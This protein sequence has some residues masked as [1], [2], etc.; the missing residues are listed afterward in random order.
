MSGVFFLRNWGG[1]SADDTFTGFDQANP[2]F[3]L[4][5]SF[6]TDV[7]PGRDTIIAGLGHDFVAAPGGENSIDGGAGDDTL[8]GQGNSDTIIGGAG[9]GDRLAGGSGADLLIETAEPGTLDVAAFLDGGEGLDTLRLIGGGRLVSTQM[10]GIEVL[11]AT[12]GT[13]TISA[14]NFA[15][16]DTLRFGTSQSQTDVLIAGLGGTYDFSALSLQ[17]LSGPLLAAARF[18]GSAGDEAVI[19]TDRADVLEGLGGN[20][21]VLGGAGN[22]AVSGAGRVRGGDGDDSVVDF[23]GAISADRLEGGDGADTIRSFHGADTLN[24]GLDDDYLEGSRDGAD[25]LLGGDGH[26]TL[27]GGA[28]NATIQHALRG[29]GG[30]DRLEA[31]GLLGAGGLFHG[32]DGADTLSVG[33]ATL[34]GATYASIELLAVAGL[35]GIGGAD[36]DAFA[37][38]ELASNAILFAASAGSFDFR[39]KTMLGT[40]AF[41]QGAQFGNDTILGSSLADTLEGAGGADNLAGFDGDDLLAG[42][43]GNDSIDGGAGFDTVRFLR[44]RAD[45]TVQSAG[46]ALIVSGIFEGAD[47]L[48]GVEELRFTDGTVP[49]VTAGNDSV[50]GGTGADSLN[51]GN[52]AD[53]VDGLAGDDTLV[54]SAGDDRVVGGDGLDRILGGNGADTLIGGAGG[55]V[56]SGQAGADLFLFTGLGD[57]LDRIADLTPGIDRIG[58]DSVAFGLAPGAL[59]AASFQAGSA[60]QALAGTAPLLIYN[61]VTGRLF[62]DADGI[63]GGARQELAVLLG[64]PALT[65]A[66]VVVIG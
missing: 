43:T 14:M 19:G 44:P 18:R 65:A 6:A 15:L 40:G 32:G 33:G 8:F 9:A 13:I 10:Q 37:T 16:F 42:G 5:T 54:G 4:G 20:N 46:S 45:Y 51:A 24:G 31:S 56:M 11:E 27:I 47:T 17:T 7:F 29:A 36:L 52:G 38:L 22:D 61:S 64:T 2:G 62:F 50:R 53:T 57:G 34:A 25:L 28:G 58:L 30:D 1:T 3:T 48:R 21:D 66:D 55:D 23:Q 59:A 12:S 60:N 63:G 41:F 49:V 39:G 35:T 26:D